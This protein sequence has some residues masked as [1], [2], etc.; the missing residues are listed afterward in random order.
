MWIREEAWVQLF[1]LASSS[2]LSV[3]L[4]KSLTSSEVGDGTHGQD[5][6]F[7]CGD[8][9]A[10]DEQGGR[11]LHLVSERFV[12]FAAHFV[13]HHVSQFLLRWVG[14]GAQGVQRL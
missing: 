2:S 8:L 13:E 12:E 7:G 1:L 14:V 5:L 11:P 9:A 10:V 4:E 6:H 3:R